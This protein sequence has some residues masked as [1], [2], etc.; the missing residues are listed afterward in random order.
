LHMPLENS[1]A[2]S[3][4]KLYKLVCWVTDRISQ[5]GKVLIHDEH[6]D[7]EGMLLASA[8]IVVEANWS[9][10]SAYHRVRTQ[11]LLEANQSQYD[12]LVEFEDWFRSENR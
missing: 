3:N 5:Q 9:A 10:R 12:R 11:R 7:R 2:L 8:V 4:E 6:G 1:E